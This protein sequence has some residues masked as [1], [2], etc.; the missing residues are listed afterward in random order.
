M[1]LKIKWL[2]FGDLRAAVF[3]SVN[4]IPHQVCL[5]TDSE[6]KTTKPKS[7]NYRDK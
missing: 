5:K 1:G 3:L 2:G 4:G 7:E 6:A